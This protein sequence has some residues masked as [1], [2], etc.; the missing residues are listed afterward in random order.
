MPSKQDAGG[1]SPSGVAI[2][3]LLTVTHLST[4]SKRLRGMDE[5]QNRKGIFND[6]VRDRFL[7]REGR[8]ISHLLNTIRHITRSYSLCEMSDKQ[9]M[10][11]FPDR[12]TLVARGWRLGRLN[13]S[14]PAESSTSYEPE[15]REFDS[16]R[17]RRFFALHLHSDLAS[18]Y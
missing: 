5:N 2:L 8:S 1:S 12:F 7:I 6:L 17:A 18:G 14:K 9:V 11:E 3:L 4:R 10:R 13:S 16:L 15:G